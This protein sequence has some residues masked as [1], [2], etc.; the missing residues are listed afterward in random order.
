V[1]HPLIGFNA[2]VQIQ[3][4]PSSAWADLADTVTFNLPDI[5]VD[6][7]EDKRLTAGRFKQFFPKLLEYGEVTVELMYTKA[8]YVRIQNLVA[9]NP[10]SFKLFAPDDDG[11]GANTAAVGVIVGFVKE[12]KGAKFQ[13]NDETMFSFVLRVNG[14]TGENAPNNYSAAPTTP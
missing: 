3:D 10:Y 11:S 5:K 9:V 14:V 2:K 1:P 13:K 12:L 7:A 6:E 8:N 4:G